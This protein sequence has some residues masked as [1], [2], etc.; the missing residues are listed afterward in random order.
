ML[1]SSRRP[2]TRPDKAIGTECLLII[3]NL[4]FLTYDHQTKWV[5]AYLTFFEHRAIDEGA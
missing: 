4:R 5:C 2:T 3:S 1:V